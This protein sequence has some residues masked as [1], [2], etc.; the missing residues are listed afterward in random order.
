[1]KV[2]FDGWPL[3]PPRSG[4]G[5]YTFELLKRLASSRRIARLDVL[6]GDRLMPF[7]D[8]LDYAE[9]PD[10]LGRLK[11]LKR[12]LVAV[13]RIGPALQS[14]ILAVR[15]PIEGLRRRRA[16]READ[17]GRSMIYHATNFI[18]PQHPGRLVV[19]IHDLSFMRYREMHP[20]QRLAWLEKGLWRTL[21]A[22][23]RIIVVSEF[24]RN[25][26][27]ALTGVERQR[28][29]VVPLGAA[30]E[31]RPRVEAET[32]STR[33]RQGLSHRGYGLFVGNL[34]PRKN[35]GRLLDAW[36]RLPG[37]IRGDFPLVVAGG[38]GWRDDRLMQ[39]LEE[40]AARGTVRLTGFV[41]AAE[42]PDL[43]ASAR[44]LA[45]PSLYE[46]FGIPVLEAMA[47]GVPVLTSNRASLP[48]VA[49]DAALLVDPE[50]VEAIAEGLA[51]L[52]QDDDLARTLS[53]RGLERA[54]TFSW[55]RCA[56]RT[57]EIYESVWAAEEARRERPL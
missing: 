1:M 26:L 45:F 15:Q 2:V 43:V 51:R 39:R 55:D 47:C 23:D 17:D 56:S 33:A 16:F 57:M 31:F 36:E 53:E 13:P 54:S 40:A 19:T 50:S 38:K 42:L 20:A 21:A 34:E 25:E 4:I 18:A 37:E 27:I 48:E 44:F 32:E 6:M 8:A 10:R 5:V 52:L 9:D 41:P 7:P 24:T 14:G 29:E 11:A 46:G 12:R 28:V 49:G 30:P 35:L 3:N 22:A